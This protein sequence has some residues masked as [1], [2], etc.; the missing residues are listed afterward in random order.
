MI[1]SF[2]LILFFVYS[3]LLFS[4]DN[5]VFLFILFIFNFIVSTIIKIP[6]KKHFK[7]FKKY[8]IFVS[9]IIICNILFSNII[10]SLKIGIKLFLA[11]DMTHIIGIYFDSNKIRL[12][13]KYLFYPLKIF[14]I[15]IDNLTLI[16]TISLAF[17]PILSDEIRMIK[18]SL[19]SK[20]VKFNLFYLITKP[21]IYLITFLNNLFNRLDDLEKALTTKAY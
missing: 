3:C 15:D 9:F 8:I 18:L 5:F 2:I 13:F 6:I 17:I 20:G 19:Q 21:H 16:I 12:A 4:I 14:K 11:I 10:D 1:N 7:L